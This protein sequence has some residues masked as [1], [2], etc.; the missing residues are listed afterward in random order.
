V[1]IVTNLLKY[2]NYIG[3]RYILVKFTA[4]MGV[5]S[6]TDYLLQLLEKTPYGEGDK[7]YFR[8]YL[9]EMMEEFSTGSK[10][11]AQSQG[12]EL[13]QMLAILI[14]EGMIEYAQ[15]G[16]F[17]TPERKIFQLVEEKRLKRH[18]EL[19]KSCKLSQMEKSER[20][21]N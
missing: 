19:L 14:K 5:N 18:L 7:C 8:G 3:S 11:I 15:I 10:N 13:V 1:A 21:D 16:G 17:L 12:R 9:S 20:R 2:K 6:L 4:L